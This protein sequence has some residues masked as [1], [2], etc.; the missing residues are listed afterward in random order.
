MSK[1][2]KKISAMMKQM[3]ELQEQIW[4]QQRMFEPIIS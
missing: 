3:E 1:Q 2:S 4:E